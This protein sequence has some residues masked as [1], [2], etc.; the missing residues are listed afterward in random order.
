MEDYR[1]NEDIRY[2]RKAIEVSVK[3]KEANK[4]TKY[5][6]SFV[7]FNN[8]RMRVINKIETD[9]NAQKFYD[10]LKNRKKTETAHQKALKAQENKKESQKRKQKK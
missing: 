1:T 3:Y 8:I 7:D 5:S 10:E 4:N 6:K 2:H 9:Q